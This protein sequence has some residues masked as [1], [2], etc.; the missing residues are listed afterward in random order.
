MSAMA[1]NK[2]KV[3]RPQQGTEA[4]TTDNNV[5]DRVKAIIRRKEKEYT[6]H[7]SQKYANSPE[8][9]NKIMRRLKDAIKNTELCLISYKVNRQNISNNR[10]TDTTLEAIVD[11]LFE[12][13]FAVNLR[14]NLKAYNRVYVL[15]GLSKDHD[16]NVFEI[17]PHWTLLYGIY[18][19]YIKRVYFD[20][21]R[22]PQTGNLIYVKCT[23]VDKEGNEY[24]H[25][26]SG[27]DIKKYQE[28]P[29]KCT[30]LKKHALRQA[31]AFTFPLVLA[32][33]GIETYVVENPDEIN[34]Q[35]VKPNNALNGSVESSPKAT[36]YPPQEE[37][38]KNN[39][40]KSKIK[41]LYNNLVN[42]TGPDYAAQVVQEYK[43]DNNINAKTSEWSADQLM[44]LI[45]HIEAAI[46]EYTKKEYYIDTEHENQ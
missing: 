42:L 24:S 41:D 37:T 7:L 6:E 36:S 44:G 29:D 4:K 2:T 11:H 23:I 22:D 20:E 28:W 26:S 15:T 3:Y 1:D 45:A 9:L 34:A 33:F 43:R 27:T 31:L 17:Y 12:L 32:K 40:L 46:E 8:K 10:I 5:V 14:V 30:M 38:S 21:V 25:T 35:Y 16:P 18:H 19:P 13:F 39:E